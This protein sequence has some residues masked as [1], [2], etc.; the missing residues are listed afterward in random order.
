ML[1]FWTPLCL[2][3]GANKYFFGALCKN[4][5]AEA[6]RVS[7]KGFRWEGDQNIPF[8]SLSASVQTYSREMWRCPKGLYQERDVTS[9]F[10]LLQHRRHKRRSLGH[11]LFG[12]THVGVSQN[13]GPHKRAERY[14]PLQCVLVVFHTFLS[15]TTMTH[16]F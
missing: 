8:L 13:S 14:R 16:T 6:R 1:L 11:R 7:E 12:H 9:T 2:V 3:V 4:S 15:V 10:I 5:G